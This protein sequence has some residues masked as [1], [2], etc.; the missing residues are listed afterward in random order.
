[1][2]EYATTPS[3]IEAV[4]ASLARTGHWVLAH[5]PPHSAFSDP[6]APPSRTPTVA[7]LSGFFDDDDD[8]DAGS[9]KS[10]PPRMYLRFKDGRPDVPIEKYSETL[11]PVSHH[12]TPAAM[13]HHPSRVASERTVRDGRSGSLEYTSGR[14]RHSQ[15]PSERSVRSRAEPASRSSS[16]SSTFHCDILDAPITRGHIP[17]SEHSSTRDISRH[18]RSPSNPPFWSHPEGEAGA[19][20]PNEG[21]AR[22]MRDGSQH[23]RHSSRS[24]RAPSAQVEQFQPSR[25]SQIAPSQHSQRAPSQHSPSNHSQAAPSRHS[26]MPPS[27]HSQIAL[28]HNPS[29][30]SDSSQPNPPPLT[31][32][33][34]SA[35]HLP[36]AV[37]SQH[38]KGA[39][40]DADAGSRHSRQS[41]G[42]GGSEAGRSSHR[43][44][45]NPPVVVAHS[46]TSQRSAQRS[47]QH[48][49]ADRSLHSRVTHEST[50]EPHH[51]VPSLPSAHADHAH[52]PGAHR[53]AIVYA[54]A[55][56]H[57]PRYAPPKIIPAAEYNGSRRGSGQREV[58]VGEEG[59]RGSKGYR[60]R[61]AHPRAAEQE[62]VV[63]AHTHASAHAHAH[64]SSQREA[65]PPAPTQPRAAPYHTV[66]R[67]SAP[68]PRGVVVRDFGARPRS[69][70][71]SRAY[72][73]AHAAVISPERQAAVV[74]PGH[75]HPPPGH[76]HTSH[77]RP[78]TAAHPIPSP[79]SASGSAQGQGQRSP[80]EPWSLV[81]TPSMRSRASSASSASTY[82]VLASPRQRVRVIA[83]AGH[84]R[85][86]FYQRL[87]T[88]NWG[89]RERTE[90]RAPGGVAEKEKEKD[91]APVN[92]EQQ[93][94]D[95][96]AE[97]RKGRRLLRRNNTARV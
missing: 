85:K 56:T 1:M 3:E 23:S 91:K 24:S 61:E 20:L 52:T 81:D 95:R 10:L 72:P 97:K 89:G 73:P 32:S 6:H 77:A 4:H 50:T 37:A 31:R 96:E 28:S 53:P 36:S 17:P 87:F 46:R 11:A 82:Y 65:N 57:V 66:P 12:P 22:S 88:V 27:N 41:N 9:R 83:D 35:I 75:H 2:T 78:G 94:Q 14:S 49:A 84:A 60:Q 92:G 13:S 74:P 51:R 55:P 34:Q 33:Q 38:S 29:A 93:G 16:R 54:P 76:V 26:H 40:I 15:A 64:A 8:V 79:P 69:Q 62:D 90:A 39:P 58:G 70:S 59:E 67:S 45:R 71:L 63:Y 47:S 19:T 43:S 18:S 7:A 42:S 44:E 48:G 86:P 68:G 30:R 5:S 21:A 25:H 80:S